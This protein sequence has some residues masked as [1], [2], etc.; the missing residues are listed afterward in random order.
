MK[1]REVFYEYNEPAMGP[2]FYPTYKKKLQ[3]PQATDYTSPG[4]VRNTYHVSFR[5]PIYKGGRLNERV[6]GWCD[7]ILWHSLHDLPS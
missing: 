4:W 1:R 6:P 5:E 7:R 3:R 2:H